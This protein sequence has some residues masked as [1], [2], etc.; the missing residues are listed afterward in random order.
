[1]LYRFAHPVAKFETG[2]TFS[3]IQT[4]ATLLADTSQYRCQLLCLFARSSKCAK[5]Q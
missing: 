2:Q 1:M 4:D 3:L 5:A